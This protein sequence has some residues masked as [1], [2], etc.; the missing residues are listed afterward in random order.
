MLFLTSCLSLYYVINPSAVSFLLAAGAVR[1]AFTNNGQV[2]LAGSRIFVERAIYDAFLPRFLASVKALRLGD[3]SSESSDVGPVSCKVH[4]DK[5]VSY[6]KLA[7]EEGG[8]IECG[9]AEVP[10]GLLPDHLKDGFFVPPTVITGLSPASR[11]AT[12]EIF[13]PVCTIHTF[14]GEE[15]AVKAVNSIKYGLAGS[16]WT[17]NLTLAHRVARRIES[18]ILWINCWLHRDLR[19]PFGGVK[20]SGL[21]REGGK[22]SL[23]FYSEWKNITVWTGAP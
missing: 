2:C 20:E 8:T 22:F 17:N 12:E 4:R 5:I 6:I 14:E 13:G 9:G 1:S 7:V 18:G 15:E 16:I 11:T 3:P 10:A 21:G 19:V 23:D